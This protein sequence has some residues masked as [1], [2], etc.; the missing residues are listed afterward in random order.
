MEAEFIGDEWD[1]D[2]SKP[3]RRK[4][5]AYAG[6]L[7]L[8]VSLLKGLGESENLYRDYQAAEGFTDEQF[9]AMIKELESRQ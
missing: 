2:S 5:P 9:D 1:S 8:A 6:P 4:N 3:V 7:E